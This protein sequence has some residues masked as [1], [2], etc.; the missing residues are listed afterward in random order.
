MAS[1]WVVAE[2]GA[3]GWWAARLAAGRPARVESPY[4]LF[5]V[6]VIYVA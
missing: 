4:L 2:G 5:I 6:C 1:V 3:A